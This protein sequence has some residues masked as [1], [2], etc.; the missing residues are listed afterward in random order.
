MLRNYDREST[1]ANVFSQLHHC[2]RSINLLHHGYADFARPDNHSNIR[3]AS[4]YIRHDRDIDTAGFDRRTDTV[5]DYTGQY[6][7]EYYSFDSSDDRTDDKLYHANEY[8]RELDFCYVYNN[9]S[10]SSS[11]SSDSKRVTP[12]PASE[13]GM[14]GRP[15]SSIQ[16]GTLSTSP[17]TGW[18]A[19]DR[20]H[21]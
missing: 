13:S 18:L 19:V 10:G 15:E 4:K 21:S 5:Y 1:V 9:V 12:A 6:N 3:P 16:S 17:S 7:H 8:G 20:R 11:S 14:S 2:P